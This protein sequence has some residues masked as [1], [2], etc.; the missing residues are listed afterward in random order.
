MKS[1]FEWAFRGLYSTLLMWMD[2]IAPCSG[3]REQV[4]EGIEGRINGLGVA[5]THEHDQRYIECSCRLEHE[6]IALLH[7]FP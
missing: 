1:M 7:A 5:S 2:S 3:I 4:V 6:V